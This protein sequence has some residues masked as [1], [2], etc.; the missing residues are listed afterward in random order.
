MISRGNG[1]PKERQTVFASQGLI[2]RMQKDPKKQNYQQQELEAKKKSG[3]ITWIKLPQ[4]KKY[5]WPIHMK[6][7]QYH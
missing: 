3:Q 2:S 6:N 4:K 7:V 5:K 1:Q